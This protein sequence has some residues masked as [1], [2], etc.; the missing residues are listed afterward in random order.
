MGLAEEH[1]VVCSSVSLVC[2]ISNQGC[3]PNDH[4]RVCLTDWLCLWVLARDA[5]LAEPQV[6][7]SGLLR[8]N[9]LRRGTEPKPDSPS[10]DERADDTAE[11]TQPC[12]WISP[13]CNLYSIHTTQGAMRRAFGSYRDSDGCGP[14]PTGDRSGS[15]EPCHVE[16]GWQRGLTQMHWRPPLPPKIANQSVTNVRNVSITHL[17]FWAC[18]LSGR[19]DSSFRSSDTRPDRIQF[20]GSR[21]S[22]SHSRGSNRPSCDSRTG[23]CQFSAEPAAEFSSTANR[24]HRSSGSQTDRCQLLERLGRRRRERPS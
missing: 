16:R 21:V 13:L 17:S 1:C 8:L 7:L 22:H 12:R 4:P 6:S 11:G 2:S 9:G 10:Y 15:D 19:T 20:L 18:R 5:L 24:R 14:F 3:S 23:M